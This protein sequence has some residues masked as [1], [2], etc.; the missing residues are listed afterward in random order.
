[1]FSAMA[2]KKVVSIDSD[3]HDILW[4]FKPLFTWLRIIGIELDPRFGKRVNL[5]GLLILLL[6]QW[7]SIDITFD[8]WRVIVYNS[9]YTER[10]TTVKW[11]IELDHTNHFILIGVVSLTFFNIAHTN[12]WQ[13]LWSAIIKFEAT[14][15]EF[16]YIRLRK[17][18]FVG[19]IPLLLV[20]FRI[21]QVEIHQ[22]LT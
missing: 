17:L 10:P 5:Y 6:H 15:R 16:S 13:N 4:C 3:P 18:F 2:S 9:N 1:M 12:Q 21:P 22:Y 14:Y 20:K 8:F 19:I 11:S 7:S